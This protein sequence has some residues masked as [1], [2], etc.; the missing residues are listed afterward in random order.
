MP[1]IPLKSAD[2]TELFMRVF[3]LWLNPNS[4]K[5]DRRLFQQLLGHVNY[6]GATVFPEHFKPG[7]KE[8]KLIHGT[9]GKN[10]VELPVNFD[11]AAR[12]GTMA[13]LILLNTLRLANED[14]TLASVENG[15]RLTEAYLMKL[16]DPRK[17]ATMMKAWK[18]CKPT[19]H[20]W[21]ALL[22]RLDIFKKLNKASAIRASRKAV[23]NATNS[24]PIGADLLIKAFKDVP[25]LKKSVEVHNALSP[26][27]FAVAERIRQTAESFYAPGQKA[28]GKPLLEP[29]IAWRI[30]ES[31]PL[32]HVKVRYKKL[33]TE[34]KKMLQTAKKSRTWSNA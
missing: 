17:R 1:V 14:E 25:R 23:A 11:A 18:A 27:Y 3:M 20:F 22:L 13:G 6:A 10:H 16:G 29:G 7:P 32:P 30:P 12:Q 33:T 19:S 15:M 5:M 24:L 21:A 9:P 2:V 26:E 31:F 8:L 4:P 28:R 34:E